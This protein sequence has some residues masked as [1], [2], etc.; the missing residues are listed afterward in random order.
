MT[1]TPI[2]APPS[3]N[4]LGP[5]ERPPRIT[6]LQ[7][8]RH[9]HRLLPV[10]ATLPLFAGIFALALAVDQPAEAVSVLFTIPIAVIAIERG[11]F[12]G[13]AAA[14]A[15]L[16]LFAIALGISD[17]HV[18]VIGFVTRGIGFGVLGGLLGHYAS[19]L[20]A[21]NSE[22]LAREEQTLSILDNTTAVIYLKDRKGRYLL[23]NHRFG[24]LFHVSRQEVVGKTDRD[25]FPQYM[26]DAF[27]AN[28]RRVLKERRVLEFEEDAPQDDGLHTYISIKFPLVRAGEEEPY[29]VCGVS[30][31]ITARKLAE[32]ELRESKDRF[33]QILDTCNEAFVS[34]NEVG[35]I[36]AWNR[37]AEE[38]FGWAATKAV[39]RRISELVLPERYREIFDEGLRRYLETGSAPI[40]NKRIEMVGLHCEGHEFPIEL[41]ITAVRVPGGH[42]FNAFVHDISG[43][44]AADRSYL[45]EPEPARS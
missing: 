2:P 41:T 33:R 43:R 45:I 30:T 22:V 31:D 17:E 26:A 32:K 8:W 12:A 28:D 19:S 44:T 27:M 4:G 34:V 40:L 7:S 35:E 29:A 18:G 36:V 13:L 5:E 14:A 1:T 21:A 24:E 3:A 23:V 16:A 11:P 6:R 10:L 37:A 38:M 20:R 39:G 25:L 42:R 9:S 15:A